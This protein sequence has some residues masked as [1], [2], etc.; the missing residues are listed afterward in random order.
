MMLLTAGL[1]GPEDGKIYGIDGNI[2]GSE[3]SALLSHSRTFFPSFSNY[4]KDKN[5]RNLW[6]SERIL[7]LRVVK[8]VRRSE[9]RVQAGLSWPLR[10]YP[11]GQPWRVTLAVLPWQPLITATSRSTGEHRKEGLV[12]LRLRCEAP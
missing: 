5:V 9:E 3:A 8:F 1:S 6:D 7:F 11:P 10:F 2:P 4:F 12:A